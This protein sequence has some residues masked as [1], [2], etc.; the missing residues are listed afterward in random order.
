MIPVEAEAEVASEEVQ[1]VMEAE[2]ASVAEEDI[3]RRFL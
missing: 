2:E 1:Q 3:F